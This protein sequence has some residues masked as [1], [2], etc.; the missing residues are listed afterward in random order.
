M[1][2]CCCTVCF[3]HMNLDEALGHTRA[4]G[5][6]QIELVAVPNWIHFTAGKDD[7]AALRALLEKHGLS[8]AAV[9]AGGIN[10]LSPQTASASVDYLE[11]VIP[12]M[13]EFGARQMVFTGSP[14]ERGGSLRHAV[15][16]LKRLASIAQGEGIRVGLENHYRNWFET[17]AD[18]DVLMAELPGPTIGITM[19][20][21]HFTSSR[22]DV[23][24]LIRR[25]GKRIQHV[26]IKDHIGTQSVA[27]GAGETQNAKHV[28]ELAQV[29]FSGYLSLELE[30]KDKENAPRYVAEAR[31]QMERWGRASASGQ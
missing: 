4:A 1:N 20:T 28:G 12:L 21:G 30:V 6:T 19:D 22:V 7:P 8:I 2:I 10:C 5:F 14:R 24:E 3:H 17:L 27:I 26:H 11:K 25:Y 16:G 29:G 31:P 9:H 15:A 13:R 18:Y 23:S